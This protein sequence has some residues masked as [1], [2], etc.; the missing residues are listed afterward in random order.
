VTPRAGA[1]AAAVDARAHQHHLAEVATAAPPLLAPGTTPKAAGTPLANITDG[2][3][4]T[5]PDIGAT[6]EGRPTHQYG[7]AR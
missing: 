6:I 5:H 7:A 3:T 2:H 1:R 4:G